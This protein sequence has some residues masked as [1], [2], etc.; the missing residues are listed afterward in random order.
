MLIRT[1]EALKPKM[2]E[3][4]TAAIAAMRNDLELKRLGVTDILINE[5]FRE[6]STQLIYWMR[7]RMQ[8]PADVQTAYTRAWGWTPT[9]AECRQKITWTLDSKHLQGVA[10]DLVP[11]RDG[12]SFWWNAPREVWDRMGTIGKQ[13]GL[14]WGG[15][16]KGREDTPHFEI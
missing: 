14:K 13:C 16:W 9:L 1:L 8:D 15:D 7:G 5:T 2:M 11:S 3:L 6:L 4:S 10:I 12:K